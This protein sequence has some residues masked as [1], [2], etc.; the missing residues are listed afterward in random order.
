MQLQER[1]A[2]LS[3]AAPDNFVPLDNNWPPYL[4]RI[5]RENALYGSEIFWLLFNASVIDWQETGK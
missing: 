1:L 2:P 5:W 3:E 4:Q